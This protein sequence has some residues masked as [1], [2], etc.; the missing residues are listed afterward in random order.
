M[1]NDI[2]NIRSL[3]HN[4]RG[5][6]VMLDTDLAECYGIEVKALNRAVKRNTD[7]FPDDFM[8]QLKK[9]EWDSLRFQFGTFNRTVSRKYLPYAFTEHGVAMLSGIL[10]TPTAI[11]VNINIIRTFTAMRQ[12][13]SGQ[14][15]F[16]KKLYELEQVLMLHIDDTN[17][18]LEGH[19][20]SINDI[21]TVLNELM[22]TPQKTHRR[23]GFG[24]HD[25]YTD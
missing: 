9:E 10:H 23:I 8:F 7:R 20:K 3:I 12:Y 4:I 24:A 14:K 18:H 2:Q 15:D 25:E 19:T 22:R 17:M 6:S 5:V 13:I 1:T 16:G 21:I 11:Q